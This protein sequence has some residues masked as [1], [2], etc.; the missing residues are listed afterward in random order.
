MA[1]RTVVLNIK[2]QDSPESASYWQEFEIPFKNDHNVISML[3]EI[4]RNPVTR[5]GKHVSAPVFTPTA[6]KR[7]A[8]RARW[9]STVAC[10]RPARRSRSIFPT[11]PRS[12]R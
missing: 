8:A 9:S 5:Q 4:R 1:E 3:M 12:S 2:R 10:A 7:Y 11:A 6:S